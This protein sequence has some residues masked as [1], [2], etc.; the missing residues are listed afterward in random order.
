M[1]I[2]ILIILFNSVSLPVYALETQ[3][4]YARVLFE[5][6]YLYKSNSND[7][8]IDNIYFEI[9]K[10]YFVEL[11]GV[12]GDFYKAKYS[13]FTGYV[14]KDCVQATSSTPISPYLNNINFRVYASE[15]ETMWS[16]PSTQSP[17][18][19]VTALP[20]L[21]KDLQFIGKIN[22]ES[23]TIGRTN[24]WYFCKYTSTNTYGYVYSDFCDEMP[25]IPTNNE[26]VEYVSNPSFE[27]K[28][29][30]QNTIPKNSNVVGIIIAIMS[31]PAVIFVFM[32]LK[33]GKI[34]NEKKVRSKEIVDY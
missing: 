32:L 8:S 4:C 18:K 33:G 27:I 20:H 34:I 16:L 3:S 26:Q 14:K 29:E 2:L 31:I 23:I 21:T 12:D 28:Q 15:S 24:V 22:G 5:Q 10:T 9:P 11:L 30:P 1:V 7:N 19:Q 17:S 13:T 25:A 6:V